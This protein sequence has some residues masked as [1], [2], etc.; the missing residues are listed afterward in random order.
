M[1][2]ALLPLLLKMVKLLF[3]IVIQSIKTSPTNFE[4]EVS[5]SKTLQTTTSMTSKKQVYHVSIPKLIPIT[6][7]KQLWNV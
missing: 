5:R 6:P 1:S 4:Q 7:T 3:K 2:N